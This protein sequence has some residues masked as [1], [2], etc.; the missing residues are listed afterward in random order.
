MGIELMHF[1]EARTSGNDQ[2][3]D[4]VFVFNNELYLV[5]AKVRSE[6]RL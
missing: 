6:S 1:D 3:L 5:E 4:I 2:E